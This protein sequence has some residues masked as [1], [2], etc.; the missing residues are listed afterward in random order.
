MKPRNILIALML[1]FSL[2]VWGLQFQNTKEQNQQQPTIEQLQ[3]ENEEM[4]KQFEQL[5]KEVEKYRGDVRSKIAELDEEQGRW[6]AWIFFIVGLIA[7]ALGGLVPYL[8][9]KDLKDDFRRR[10]NELKVQLEQAKH[11][12]E[13]SKKALSTIE[14]LDQ[15]I[16]TIKLEI[17]KKS[18][19]TKEY[20]DSFLSFEN[21]K[22][23]YL[24]FF[25]NNIA[26]SKDSDSPTDY[27]SKAMLLCLKGDYLEAL[28]VMNNA[29]KQDQSNS[30]YY[31][32]RGKI[33]MRMNKF[34]EA[35]S[36]YSKV[37]NSNPED[38]TAYLNRAKCYKR[39][40]KEESDE[41]MKSYYLQQAQKD[42]DKANS[43]E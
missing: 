21:D 37:I 1:C 17:D 27:Y 9:N 6:A 22:N 33:Y 41:M 43:L 10:M 3:K 12:A 23:Y 16:K 38:K 28:Q 25:S 8:F 7:A 18:D 29:I 42:E 2:N 35:L 26:D 36:D 31:T 13:S 14:K 19:K 20:Y 40:A 32:L 39:M 30:D 5:E 34:E 24:G 4:L 15:E 11:D